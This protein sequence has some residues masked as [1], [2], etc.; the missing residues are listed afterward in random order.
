MV[1][2]VV[3]MMVVVVV[4]WLTEQ[5]DNSTTGKFH[6]NDFTPLRFNL[7]RFTD[8]LGVDLAQLFF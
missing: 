3:V 6:C 8:L 1:M 4:V 7:L 2:T 5:P